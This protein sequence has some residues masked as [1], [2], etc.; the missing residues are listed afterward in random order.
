MDLDF[1]HD[2]WEAGE[3]GFHEGTPNDLLVEH[4]E[5]LPLS[6]GQRV[7]VPLCGMSRDV[8][9]LRDRGVEVVGAEVNEDAVRRLFDGLDLA[10]DVQP[11]G[12]GAWFS[13]DGVDI[14][15]GDVFDISPGMLGPVDAV[16]DRAALVA[17]PDE[18]RRRYTHHLVEVSGRA[19]QLVITFEY[20]PEQ[21][22]GPPFS[23]PEAELRRHYGDRYRLTRAASVD[24]PGGL[25][26]TCP[27]TENAW[28]L[29]PA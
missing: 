1:W 27:A 15:C 21:M 4:F 28:V 2:K 7:F 5:R 22:D 6:A 9:W 10:P 23:I 3:I 29:E 14:Y 13:R 20:D 26:G 18:T 8:A 24:V 12:P 17:L 11:A 19:P 16:Y 25:K